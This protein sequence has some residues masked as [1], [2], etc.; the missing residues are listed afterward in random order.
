MKL[1]ALFLGEKWNFPY[2]PLNGSLRL[3]ELLNNIHT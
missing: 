1:V 2:M 3:E